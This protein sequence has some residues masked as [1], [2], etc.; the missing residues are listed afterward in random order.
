MPC[1]VS[2]TSK[3]IPTVN[4]CWLPLR[5]LW[6]LGWPAINL[7]H[8]DCSLS[9]LFGLG[10]LSFFS[11]LERWDIDISNT[12]SQK[13]GWVK[14]HGCRGSLAACQCLRQP[15]ESVPNACNVV[16]VC[17]CY[18]FCL[19]FSFGRQMNKHSLC[20]QSMEYSNIIPDTQPLTWTWETLI[21]VKQ[22]FSTICGLSL[23]IENWSYE[24]QRSHKFCLTRCLI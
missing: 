24:M 11:W 6:D 8:L 21:K 2:W 23:L 15:W 5:S 19:C 22:W 13:C 3:Y 12:Y 20:F 1:G 17:L 14:R 18:C 4:V 9:H 7:P 16:K 10:G